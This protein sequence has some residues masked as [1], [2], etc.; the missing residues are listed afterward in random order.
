MPVSRRGV[1]EPKKGGASLGVLPVLGYLE[2]NSDL[3]KMLRLQV[4]ESIRE[5]MVRTEPP[6]KDNHARCGFF[7]SFF[8]AKYTI[9]FIMSFYLSCSVSSYGDLD[10]TN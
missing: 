10:F 1:N 3:G 6:A 2:R 5:A 8:L 9:R 4:Q 7:S